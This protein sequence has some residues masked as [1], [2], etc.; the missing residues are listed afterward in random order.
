[1]F[2]NSGGG[3]AFSGLALADT[4]NKAQD[5][6]G[7]TI[8]AHASGIVASAAVP[9][10]A[11]CNVRMAAAGTIFMVHEAALWKWPGRETASDIA[12]QN[13][14][15]KLLRDRYI[16]YLVDNSTTDR[17]TWESMEKK[18]SW[19]NVDTARQLGLIER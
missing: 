8:R 11:V 17:E 10:F 16:G 9:V 1:M 5:K 6:W 12:S 15:M 13:E 7:F 19:F 3:D 14:L 2:I 4:I 18:T